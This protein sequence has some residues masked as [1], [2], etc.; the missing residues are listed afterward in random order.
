MKKSLAQE[1]LGHL[2]TCCPKL[3]VGA[4]FVPY[5]QGLGRRLRELEKITDSCQHYFSRHSPTTISVTL[6]RMK[7]QK[8]VSVT[9]PNKKAVWRITQEGRNHFKKISK[10]NAVLPPEDGKT[11]IAMF[12][13]SEDRKPER[14]WLRAKLLASD[15]TPLQKSVF[16]GTR[17]LPKELLRE[18]DYRGLLAH[19]HVVALEK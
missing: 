12:D 13:I 16:L 1:I 14:D 6:N 8:L 11:R 10:N 4:L 3:V 19:V 9:G 15:Y 17:P 7:K 5:G 18:L 2:L